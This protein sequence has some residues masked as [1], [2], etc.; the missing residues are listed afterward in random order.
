MQ[1]RV[2]F[3][4]SL[5]VICS[6]AIQQGESRSLGQPAWRLYLFIRFKGERGFE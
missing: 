6:V 1:S 2:V 5:P 4:Q 3:P